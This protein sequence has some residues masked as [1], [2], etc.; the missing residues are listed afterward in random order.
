MGGEGADN[1]PLMNIKSR[2]RMCWSN[3]KTLNTEVEQNLRLTLKHSYATV[4][5][6]FAPPPPKKKIKIKNET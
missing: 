6:S 5:T 3:S 4:Y 2:S 1:G